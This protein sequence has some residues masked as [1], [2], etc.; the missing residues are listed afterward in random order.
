[1]EIKYTSRSMSQVFMIITNLEHL[2][3]ARHFSMMLC[4]DDLPVMCY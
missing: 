3:H 1:M 4:E 2:R